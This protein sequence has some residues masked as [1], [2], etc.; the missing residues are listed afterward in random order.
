MSKKSTKPVKLDPETHDIL[1]TLAFE[2]TEAQNFK[3]SMGETVKRTF[4]INGVK[5]RLLEDAKM[6]R[7]LKK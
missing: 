5:S 2:I 3:V 4:N 7:R 6:K 1:Q